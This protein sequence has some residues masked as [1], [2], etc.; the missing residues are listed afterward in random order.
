MIVKNTFFGGYRMTYNTEFFLGANTS[1][2]F[3]SFFDELYN[4]YTDSDVYIIKGGP[5]TGKSTFMKKVADAL[6]ESGVYTERI[7]CASDPSSLDAV[8]APEKGFA[9]A[10]GTAP[11]T[12]EPRFP[13]ASENIINPGQF[14]DSRILRKNRDRILSLSLENSLYHRRS[15]AYLSAAGSIARQNTAIVSRYIKEEKI[16]SFSSRFLARELPRKRK[17]EPGRRMRRFLSAITPSGIVFKDNTVKR[18]AARV[19]ALD[20]RYGA[21]SSLICERIGEG[22]LASG[23]DVIF[24]YCPM[25]PQKCEHIIIPEKNIAIISLSHG[26]SYA[27]SFDRVIHSSRFLNEGLKECRQLLR[28]N[29]RLKSE[30]TSQAVEMLKKA[31]STHDLL[32]S[33]YIKAM[34]FGKMNSFC[35]N[36]IKDTV[37][38]LIN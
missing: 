22:A 34:D 12:L 6:E 38:P 36:F 8:I 35:E 5:G 10:D 24:C 11:H 14:W 30:L 29:E 26:H 1:G 27:L 32:E 7:Y 28:F 23:Y 20:D 25:N 4:P 33:E 9:I 37:R 3:V 21:V 19:F 15:A 2:G 16:H 13:G 31:K 17:T 18:T